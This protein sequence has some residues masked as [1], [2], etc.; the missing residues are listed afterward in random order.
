M[1]TSLFNIVQLFETE[2]MVTVI[3]RKTKSRYRISQAWY[4]KHRNRYILIPPR[5]LKKSYDVDYHQT[6]DELDIPHTTTNTKSNSDVKHFISIKTDKIEISNDHKDSLEKYSKRYNLHILFL[7]EPMYSLPKPLQTTQ[8]DLKYMVTIKDLNYKDVK[9]FIDIYYNKKTDDKD[10]PE[11]V[12]VSNSYYKVKKVT[13]NEDIQYF[14]IA[15]RIYNYLFKDEIRENKNNMKGKQSILKQLRGYT[16]KLITQDL[17]PG[18][19]GDHTDPETLDP[20][21][22]E[23][24]ILVQRQHT[25]NLAIAKQIAV[26][27]LTQHPKYY[28]KLIRA[29]LVDEKPALKL[30][31]ANGILRPDRKQIDDEQP[32]SPTA[33]QQ[34]INIKGKF[35]LKSNN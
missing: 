8:Y 13:S 7:D 22:L 9:V 16:S 31:R 26:D 29:G 4:N 30:A 18:G 27:H 6:P 24:G 10:V 14:K 3:N 19:V 25:N 23:V 34:S 1:N 12:Q 5:K 11:I 32:Q 20:R 33:V 15:L 28:T 2:R 21:Q 17:L 35:I